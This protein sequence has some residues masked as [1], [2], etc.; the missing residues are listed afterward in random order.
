MKQT[1]ITI[2]LLHFAL[3]NCYAQNEHEAK[4]LNIESSI[5]PRLQIE[6]KVIPN[7]TITERMDYY[8]VPGLS[9]AFFSEGKVQWTKC[10][11]FSSFD[12]TEQINENTLFQAASISKSLTSYY[13]MTLMEEGILELDTDVNEYLLGWNVVENEYTK[14]D[15]VSLRNL[16]SHT[17]GITVSGFEGYNSNYD[18]IPNIIQILNGESPANSKPI[19]PNI[20]P[21]TKWRYSGGGYVIIQKIIEDLTKDNFE[22]TISQKV[23]SKLD[24]KNS[25][26][27]QPPSTKWVENIARGHDKNRETIDGGWNI[28]PEQAAAGL[29]ST[30][31]DIAKFAIAFQ[32][33]YRGESIGLISTESAKEMLKLY[34]DKWGLGFKIN[35]HGNGFY[36]G[37]SGANVGYR[38]VLIILPE[39]NEGVVI[40]SNGEFGAPLHT[41]ILRSISKEYS[42][43]IFNPLIK[44]IH[45]LSNKEKKKFTG[46]YEYVSD[47]SLQLNI[48]LIKDELKVTQ[49]W[50][51]ESYIIYPESSQVF[52]D[53][54]HGDNFEFSLNMK[55]KVKK[56]TTSGVD[57]FKKIK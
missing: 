1:Y 5:T 22:K 16:L 33:L 40:M 28:Y 51:K 8:R 3:L 6:G 49:L 50:D 41:D 14:T 57:E 18:S 35:K 13:V 32:K 47:K 29:W 48:S 42:W 54:V 12:K 38:S 34:D 52:F 10:Y 11:G 46:K 36:Y 44:H 56:L 2:I 31:T 45:T 24:M 39:Y 53:E 43:D 27:E 15:K 37:H 30:P 55:G 4:K 17:G 20:E 25:T 21:N 9:I 26:F 19:H 7:W 23:L